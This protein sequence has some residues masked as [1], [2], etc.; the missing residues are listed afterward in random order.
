MECD[1]L[2]GQHDMN[3][4]AQR[5]QNGSHGAFLPACR[6]VKQSC[7]TRLQAGKA[8]LLYPY[9]TPRC[10]SDY[11]YIGGYV[12][13]GITAGAGACKNGELYF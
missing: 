3:S 7:F 11:R 5:G 10:H 12:D 2:S 6:R 9:R 4:S 13:A 1:F 8:V